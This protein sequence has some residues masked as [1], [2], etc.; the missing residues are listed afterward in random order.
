MKLE[1]EGYVRTTLSPEDDEA[2]TKLSADGKACKSLATLVAI[3][4]IE[5]WTV[6]DVPLPRA[7]ARVAQNEED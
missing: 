5:K 4:T 6:L 1:S 7:R 3:Q 2:E